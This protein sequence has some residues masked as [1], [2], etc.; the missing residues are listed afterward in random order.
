[1]GTSGVALLLLTVGCTNT[2]PDTTTGS[3]SPLSSEKSLHTESRPPTTQEVDASRVSKSDIHQALRTDTVD[4]TH[5]QNCQIVDSQDDQAPNGWFIY[6]WN[7]T[8]TMGLVVSIHR[9]SPA[10][11]RVGERQTLNI[12]QRDAFVMVEAGE[13]VDKNFCV[14]KIQEIPMVTVLESQNG[15]IHLARTQK[16]LSVEIVDVSL[17]DQYSGEVVQLSRVSIQAGTLQKPSR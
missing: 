3:S 14:R 6:A 12:A 11:I 17:K 15:S 9:F 10:D 8:G 5:T 16:G 2:V 7:S 13:G 1:M 4:W